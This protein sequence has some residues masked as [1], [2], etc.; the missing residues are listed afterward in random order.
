MKIHWIIFILLVSVAF[1]ACR[2][3]SEKPVRIYLTEVEG[4]PEEFGGIS[5]GVSASF[6]GLIDDKL[7]IAGGC[8]F[9]DIPAADGGKYP[10]GQ[11]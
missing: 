10:R 3:V 1:S 2:K 4:I 8:N 11:L 6:A 7:L 9:P 5:K